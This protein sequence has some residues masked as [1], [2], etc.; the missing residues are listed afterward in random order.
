[1]R[2]I[3]RRARVRWIVIAVCL[4]SCLRLRS[5]LYAVRFLIERSILRDVAFMVLFSHAVMLIHVYHVKLTLSMYNLSLAQT[6]FGRRSH[7]IG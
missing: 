7:V 2:C 6:N 3:C 1:M 5:K 4:V